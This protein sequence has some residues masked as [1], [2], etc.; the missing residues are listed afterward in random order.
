MT[1]L[2]QSADLTVCT[3]AVQRGEVVSLELCS[4]LAIASCRARLSTKVS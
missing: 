1:F 2:V 3:T 4:R